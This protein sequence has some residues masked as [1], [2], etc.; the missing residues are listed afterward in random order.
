MLF[1]VYA[2]A[3]PKLPLATR[4]VMAIGRKASDDRPRVN[5]LPSHE[6]SRRFTA[7]ARKSDLNGA[8]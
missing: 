2:R 7:A 1:L 8:A 6:P 3:G 4:L 5:P